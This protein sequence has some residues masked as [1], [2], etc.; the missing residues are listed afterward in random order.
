MCK[1]GQIQEAY[2]IAIAD[3]EADPTN[4]WTQREVGWA[5][6]Y[7]IKADTERRD[8]DSLMEHIEK[9]KSLDMLT[10]ESDNLIYD[11]VLFSIGWFIRNISLND[12]TAFSKLSGIFH[13]LRDYKFSPSKGHSF[14][15][16][17]VIKFAG[18]LEMADFFDWWNLDNLRKEDYEPFITE[19]GN[20]LMTLAERA[21]IANSKALLQQHD[22]G[23]VEQFLPKLDALMEAHPEMIYP[24]YFY[25][26]LLLSLGTTEEEALKVIIPFAQQKSR[27]FWVWQLISDVFVNDEE[28]QLACLLRAVN[29]PTQENFLGKLRIRLAD[30]Y[31]S[32]RMYDKARFHIDKV[33]RNYMKQGWKMPPEI[34]NWIHEPWLNSAT[35][36]EDTDIDY[37][38][39][40]DDII[41]EGT[42]GATAFVT[43]I[44][45][46]GKRATLIYGWK[47]R[48]IQKIHVDLGIGAVLNVRYYIDPGGKPRILHL[49]KGKFS[50]DLDYA[51]IVEGTIRKKGQHSYAFLSTDSHDYFIK[52]NIV[53]RYNLINGQKAMGLII[54]DYFPKKDLWTW[55]CLSLKVYEDGNV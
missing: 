5:L 24:G 52:P 11:N 39:I 19:R 8:F 27:E 10:I 17:N 36:I 22:K 42:K 47:K 32:H 31:V 25:G 43:Y 46:E 45:P 53:R 54:Y 30:F 1:A 37:M 12:Q 20:K 9:L 13:A 7:M 4:V 3:W 28:K 14:L 40:T 55:S 29:C 15:M 21:F 34:D 49:T 18:W 33:A 38:G 48:I 35:P 50:D 26:K 51:K 23:R 6:Y 44:N 41:C 2:D 16:Q